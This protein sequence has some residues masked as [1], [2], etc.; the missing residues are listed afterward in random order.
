M[1]PMHHALVLNQADAYATCAIH[2]CS[3]HAMYTDRPALCEYTL[4]LKERYSPNNR[5]LSALITATVC[6]LSC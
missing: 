2:V 5:L 3:V 6:C 4:K 1:H